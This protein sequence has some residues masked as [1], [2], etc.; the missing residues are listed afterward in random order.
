MSGYKNLISAWYRAVRN[1]AMPMLCTS[2]ILFPSLVQAFTATSLGD[3]G[4]VSVMQVSGNFDAL[5]LDGTVN[6][7]PRQAITK[8]FLKTHKDEYDFVVIFSKFDYKMPETEASAFYSGI[9]NDVRG[10]GQEIF[11]YSAEFGSNGKLQGTIDMGNLSGKSSDPTDPNFDL[12]LSTLAHEMLHRWVARVKFKEADGT[13]STKLL[14]KNG[15]HW[16]YLLD[17]KGSVAYGN[18]WRD[19]GNGT[20]T[21]LA[22]KLYFSPLDLYLMGVRDKS[23]VPPMLLI[24]NPDIDPSTMLHTSATISG[25]A[26][27]ISIDDIVAAEGERLPAAKDSQKQFKMAFIFVTDDGNFSGD[28]LAGIES[29]RNGFLTRFSI[30]TDGKALVQIASTPKEDLPV[31]SGVRPVS[32]TP[33]TLPPNVNEGVSWLMSHQQADGS[34]VDFSLT[35]ARDTAEVAATLQRFPVAQQ[36]LQGG[37]QW[38]ANN[39]SANID[40]L[41]RRIEAVAASGGDAALLLQDLVGRRNLDGGWGSARDFESNATDTALALKALAKAG[42]GDQSVIAKAVAYLQ[43]V[44][45]SDGGWSG[46]DSISTIQPTAAVLAAFNGYRKS[47]SL[48]GNISQAIAFLSGKQNTDGGFGNSPSTV[49]DSALAVMA[50]Q[51]SGA[52]KEMINRGVGYLNGLQ[53]GEGSWQESPYQTALAVRAVWQANVDPDLAVATH[54][55]TFIPAEITVLPTQAVVNV[56][57]RNLGQTDVAQAKVAIYDGAVAP[58]K[59]VGEQTLAFPGS[60][61]VTVTFSVP[62]NDGN[63]HTFYVVVDPDNAVKEASKVN[64]QAANALYPK[65]TYDFET[66]SADFTAAPNTIDMYQEVRLSAKVSN[67]GTMT[68]YNVPVRFYLEDPAAPLEIATVGVDIPAGGTV[69]KE[70]TWKATKAGV[71]TLAVQVDPA[72]T[73]TESSK[74]NNSAAVPITVNSLTREEANLTVSYKDIVLTPNPADQGGK[75]TLDAVVKN[76]GNVDAS[77]VKVSF[78]NGVPGTGG[79]LIGSRTIALLAP[80][81]AQTVSLELEP[82]SEAGTKTVYVEVDP[83]NAVKE[84]SEDDNGAYGTLYIRSFPDIVVSA[85]SMLLSPAAPK[86]GD[87]L[88]F[89][90]GVSNRGEQ[91]ATKVTV[92]LE[93]G[94]AVVGSVVIPVIAGNST[95]TASFNYD[96]AGRQGIHQLT[97]V[98][99][100]DDQL[101][102]Q[103]KDNNTATKTFAVQNSKLWVSEPYFSPNGDGVKDSTHVSFRLDAPG[104]VRVQVLDAQGRTIRSFQDGD[105]T[106]TTGA[107]VT[108]DGRSDEGVVVKDGQ[109]QIQIRDLNDSMVGTVDVVVD[110]NSSPLKEALLANELFKKNMTCKASAVTGNIRTFWL[111][112]ESG[113]VWGNPDQMMFF[114]VNGQEPRLT[115]KDDSWF[116]EVFRRPYNKSYLSYGIDLTPWWDYNRYEVGFYG[117]LHEAKNY[118]YYYIGGSEYMSPV[119]AFIWSPDR[120]KM[121]APFGGK[122]NSYPNNTYSK[123][124]V[125]EPF[126]EDNPYGE[127]SNLHDLYGYGPYSSNITNTV[128]WS[129]DSTRLVYWDLT[130]NEVKITDPT[131]TNKVTLL[132]ANDVGALKWLDNDRILMTRGSGGVE[133]VSAYIIGVNEKS[134]S[135]LTQGGK[136]VLSNDRSKIFLQ[137]SQRDAKVVRLDGSQLGTFTLTNTSTVMPLW[138]PKDRCLA[139]Q[140]TTQQINNY[141]LDTVTVFD[142]ATGE[143]HVLDNVHN[144]TVNWYDDDTLLY[145]KYNSGIVLYDLKTRTAK[146]LDSAGAS[147]AIP[148]PFSNYLVWGGGTSSGCSGVPVYLVS[149]RQ[150]LSAGVTAAKK[151]SSLVISGTAADHNF[152]GWQLEYADRSAPDTWK[153]IAPPSDTPVVEGSFATWVPP[154]EGIYHIRLT[155]WDKAGNNSVTRTTVTWSNRTGIS[156]IYK[157]LDAISPNGDGINDVLEVHYTLPAPVHVDYSVYDSGGALV[158]SGYASAGVDFV[159]WDGRDEAGGIVSDGRYTIALLGA[160]FSFTV[161]NTAPI[162]SVAL[163]ALAKDKDGAWYADLTAVAT[164]LH[165][166]GWKVEYAEG[167]NPSQWLPLMEGREI[168]AKRDDTGSFIDP[169][170]QVTIKSFYGDDVGWLKN[171]KFRISAEDL[172]GNKSY[173]ISKL[174]EEKVFIS[175]WDFKVP[176]EVGSIVPELAKPGNHIISGAETLRSALQSIALQHWNGTVWTDVASAEPSDSGRIEFKWDNSSAS[177]HAFAVRISVKDILGEVHYSNTLFTRS[178]L[179]LKTNCFRELLGEN[180]LFEAVSTLKLQT[181]TGNA[182]WSDYQV[183]DAAKGDVI[184]TECFFV[185]APL[186]P[187]GSQVRMTAVGASGRLYE[188]DPLPYPLNC[189]VKLELGATYEEATQCGELSSG[190]VTLTSRLSDSGSSV[191]LRTLSYYLQKPSGLEPLK[192]YDVATEGLRPQLLQTAGMEEGSYQVKAV[193]SYLDQQDM[194]VKEA[195]AA[196]TVIVDRSLPVAQI[197][198]P[199]SGLQ[200]L[201]PAHYSTPLEWFGLAVEGRASDNIGTK[202]Y[203]LSYG[204]GESPASWSPAA[205]Q[206]AGAISGHGAKQGTLGVW[207]VS[208]LGGGTYSL[209]LEVRDQVG[210]LNCTTTLAVL[211]KMIE[212]P[213]VTAGSQLFSPNSDGINDDLNVSFTLQEAALYDAKVFRLLPSGSLDTTPVRTIYA[214]AKHFAGSEN[215]IWDGKSDAGA[216]VSD[217]RYAVAVTV[218]DG[219]GNSKSRWAATEVDATPPVATISYPTLGSG[220]LLGNLVEVRGSAL[221]AHLQGYI[222][223]AGKGEVPESWIAIASGTKAIDGGIFG[224]WNTYGLEGRWTLRLTVVDQAGNK[225]SG[226][227]VVDLGIRR[228]LIKSMAVSPATFSPNADGKKD[229]G[230]VVY[231]IT[232]N[233]LVDL[234]VSDLKG[235]VVK[236]L[237]HAEASAGS[238]NYAWDGRDN[239]GSLLPDGDYKVKLH[240]VSVLD[241]TVSQNEEVT[242]SLDATPPSIVVAVPAPDAFLN[243]S[244]LDL[245][246]DIYDE[247]LTGYTLKVTGPLGVLLE[248]S[249]T[250]NRTGFSFGIIPELAEESYT[251]VSEAKDA[252]DNAKTTTIPFTVDRTP[253]KATLEAPA[254]GGYFGTVKAQVGF[255]GSVLEK[256]PESYSLKFGVGESPVDWHELASGI[257]APSLSSVAPLK[258]GKGD[259]IADG[260]YTIWLHARDKAALEGDAKIKI[261]VDNTVP[262]VALAALGNEEYLRHPVDLMGTAFDA[263]FER[264]SL[265]LSEGECAGAFKWTTLKTLTSTVK[266]GLLY[267]WKVLPADGEYCLRLSAT[268]RSGGMS[269]AKVAVKVHV[270]A[271]PAPVLSA[272]LDVKTTA[273][274]EWTAN[275]DVVA[276]NVYRNSEKLNASPVTEKTFTDSSLKGGTYGYFVKAVDAAGIDSAPS[277]TVSLTV[278]LAGPVLGMSSPLP[279]ARVSGT[280]DINGTATGDDFKRYTLYQGQGSAPATWNQI[281]GSTAPLPYGTLGKLNTAGFSEGSYTLKLEAE[282]INGNISVLTRA[283]TVDRSAPSQPVLLSAVASGS[284]VSVTWSGN[285]E[286]DLAGYLLMRNGQLVNGAGESFNDMK[287]FLLSG[288]VYNETLSDGSY[289]YLLVAVDTAGNISGFS[290]KKTVKVDASPPHAIL[291]EPA[292]GAKIERATLKASSP[293]LDIVSVQFQYKGTQDGAWSNLGAPVTGDSF[294]STFDPESLG[295]SYGNYSLRSVATDGGGKIDPAPAAITITYADITAPAVPGGLRQST[296]GTSVS[297]SWNASEEAGVNYNVY[298]IS[299]TTRSKINSAWVATSSY[300]DERLA[301]GAY[302]Y[303]VTAIDPFQNE[304]QPSGRV[305]TRIYAPV[306]TETATPV[307]HPLV[308]LVGTNAEPGALVQFVVEGAQRQAP[309]G[310][311]SA[312]QEGRYALEIEL[313]P[314]VNTITAR[315]TD[316]AGNLSR[317]SKAVSV[318]YSVPP[319]APAGIAVSVQGHDVAL[320]W[321]PNPENDVIGYNVFRDGQKINLPTA[322]TSGNAAASSEYW[323]DVARNALDGNA[324]TV[325]TSKISYGTFTPAWWEY[326]MP[327]PQFISSLDIH[328]LSSYYNFSGKDYEVQA[329]VVDKWIPLVKV[330]GNANLNPSYSFNPPVRTDKVRIY[331]SATNCQDSYYNRTSIIDVTVRKE[332]F[333]PQPPYLDQNL[334]DSR[335]RYQVAAVNSVGFEGSRSG[336]AVAEV[337]DI[338]APA[339]PQG[340]AATVAGSAVTLKWLPN[341]ETDLAGYNVYRSNSGAWQKLNT[342]PVQGIQLEDQ[343]LLNGGYAYRLTAVDGVGNESEPTGE[344]AVVVNAA[345]PPAPAN[346]AVV[347]PPEGKKLQLIWEASGGTTAGYNVLRSLT[348]SGGYQKINQSLLTTSSYV[349]T[350]VSNGTRYFY[351]VTA[352]DN[353]GNAGAFSNEVCAVPGD[354]TVP[355]IPI[356]I[357]PVA[358]G[359]SLTVTVGESAVAG[360]A[361]AGVTVKLTNNGE[362]VASTTASL[363]DVVG[364]ANYYYTGYYYSTS[365]DGRYFCS[366]GWNSL[367]LIDLVTGAATFVK[368]NGVAPVTWSPDSKKITFADYTRKITVYDTETGISSRLTEDNSASEG[369]PNWSSDGTKVIF[370][371]T[372]GGGQNAWIKDMGTGSLTQV[373]QGSTIT[374]PKFVPG[375]N[376]VTYFTGWVVKIMDLDTGNTA[377][378]DNN[379]A[380]DTLSWSPDGSR[381]SFVSWNGKYHLY[382]A[383]KGAYAQKR[384]LASVSGWMRATWAQDSRNIALTSKEN[385]SNLMKVVITDI[386]GNAREVVSTETGIDW[387]QWPASGVIYFSTNNG[388]R[389]I[390]PKGNFA[391]SGVKL[392][393]GENELSVTAVDDS[394]NASPA[395]QLASVVYDPVLMPDLALSGEDFTFYPMIAQPGASVAGT[396][397]IRNPSHNPVTNV[398]VD[399]Y[400]WD[401]DGALN[402]VK[403]EIVPLIAAESQETVSFSFNTGSKGGAESVIAIVD[404]SGQIKELDETNNYAAGEIFV[405]DRDGVSVVPTLVTDQYTAMEEVAISV[406][407]HNNGPATTG[408]L[409]VAIEDATGSVVAQLGSSSIDQEFGSQSY[410]LVWNSG[411]TP[412]GTYRVRSTFEAMDGT[413]TEGAIEFEI[414]PDLRLE[415]SVSTDKRSYGPN[416]TVV[417]E[418]VIKN[419][420]STYLIPEVTVKA[421]VSDSQGNQLQMRNLVLKNL[422]PGTSVLLKE[423]WNT[424]L[425]PPGTYRTSAQA[426]V[427]GRELA[428]HSSTF[429]VAPVERVTGTVQVDPSTV[430]I[431]SRII[432][433]YSVGSSGNV[434]ASGI[435]K[436]FVVD[437]QTGATLASAEQEMEFPLN[438]MRI[439]EFTFNASSL[440][441]QGYLLRLQFLSLGTLTAVS[442]TGF[443]VKDLSAPVVAVISP[444]AGEICNSK[445]AIEVLASDDA[446]GV[447]K[448]EYQLDGGPWKPLALVSAAQGRYATAWEPGASE[449]PAHTVSFRATDRSGN[450]STPVTVAFELQMDSTAPV[451]TIDIEGPR[452]EVDGKLYVSSATVFTLAGS[453][454]FSGVANTEYRIDGGAWTPYSPFRLTTAGES[455]V[456]YRSVDNAGNP[457][458]EKSLKVYLDKDAPTTTITA[459]DPLAPGAVNTVSPKTAFTLSATDTGTGIKQVWYRIDEGQWL[460]FTESFTLEEMDAGS[461]TIQFNAIDNVGNEEVKNSVTVRLIRIEVEKEIATEPVVLIGA[462]TDNLNKVKNQG[463]VDAVKPILSSLGVDFLIARDGEEFKTALRSG[464]YNS[465]LLID[466]KDE[467]TGGELREAVNYG[468]SLV[469][470][471]TKPGAVP[472]LEIV[473]GMKLTGETTSEGIPVIVA[474]SPLTT[475]VT[476]QSSGKC[477]VGSVVAD[478]A[479]VFGY[480]DDKRGQV[481]AV[482]YNEYGDGRVVLFTFDLLNSSQKGVAA[483]LLGDAVKLVTPERREARALGTIPIEITV[484]NSTEPVKLR[485]SEMFPAE[486][487]ARDITPEG[488]ASDAAITWLKD[489]DPT[490]TMKFRY[491]LDLPDAKGEYKA[492]TNIYYANHEEYRLYEA[493]ELTLAVGSDSSDLLGAAI[494]DL[495]AVPAVT[496]EDLVHLAELQSRLAQINVKP[497]TVKDAEKEIESLTRVTDLVRGVSADTASVRL[498]LDE[499]LKVLERKWYLLSTPGMDGGPASI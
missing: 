387:I 392:H 439:G 365:P 474:Q 83:E 355:S 272:R 225:S 453:D 149:S 122:F 450:Q 21:S 384:D 263:N 48:E 349:D 110:N 70:V 152:G 427:D 67:K 221:D 292:N 13:L 174:V 227:V 144:G 495:G 247:H 306:L 397:T 419:P 445:V 280:V 368:M 446:S 394:G 358:A 160:D 448:L 352:A 197:T 267:S 472:S 300:L 204:A 258:V 458:Q 19:N 348:A 134:S 142:T 69:T 170:T 117:W 238:Y 224:T 378:I 220:A 496:S 155:A 90:V 289:D 53:T 428:T 165:L 127:S 372:R 72:N 282:D 403:S 447:E 162:S 116:S 391:F 311:V 28:Q 319:T 33:R 479:S 27:Q 128:S 429:I 229:T 139:L 78:Y 366:S 443:T 169:P 248:R 253:P 430:P 386:E 98:V 30:L 18:Q 190:R 359:G 209:R 462:W 222:L 281:S 252:A 257:S 360:S 259:G 241:S 375:A 106:G 131:A 40:Y 421:V 332:E 454:D 381:L 374:Y 181:K 153:P 101:V 345:L 199:A 211:D 63:G 192:S 271:P 404:Q 64:N 473:F 115:N 457:E 215:F 464:K 471:K 265:E 107:V 350:S 385:S 405:A 191:V 361:E 37:L 52:D 6:S 380:P 45:N 61:S 154:G 478:T 233:S 239:G 56:S 353:V 189:P 416:Q 382:V 296:N 121:A 108:W 203:K 88:S 172:A 84:L 158:K 452:Y 423:P 488:A 336:E 424:A 316:G 186:L 62:V 313:S 38:L 340:F 435:L 436:A 50:L 31:N 184:P 418:M 55:I 347:A 49:Y 105:L 497:L 299:E 60:S 273:I 234:T 210:N 205:G 111:D 276:Y 327:A 193:L 218:M 123:L 314:G 175:T 437:P 164:D 59:K 270:L 383:D 481:P 466:Y 194:R 476:L 168:V 444:V 320:A 1:W 17:T 11:D 489:L 35:A 335:F 330:A 182:Q 141:T 451:T 438:E 482:V 132:P 342:S 29:I 124:S 469:Y 456:Y 95:T 395:S 171:K 393:I 286:T 305:T 322:D 369:D 114:P 341:S 412:A 178:L 312:D 125:I 277:N 99:D 433:R 434:A 301:D 236:S 179:T 309:V 219:C 411:G 475:S 295:L 324:S 275:P 343:N 195:S 166:K 245:S 388:V 143:T 442:S 426:F 183:Y 102:E 136:P 303:E 323:S 468:D 119:K 290:N 82:L 43:R 431:G 264:G 216:T 499:L 307:D 338:V 298:R 180:S 148:S 401:T 151:G 86:E 261:V 4:N 284:T 240:V 441:P 244:A 400:A 163:T 130:T 159:A 246:G 232:A 344:L 93:E 85:S 39:A 249:G 364:A 470:I 235:I 20:F 291:V 16:S 356:M 373:T 409:K 71:L 12:T 484:A 58:D 161:D 325:W 135:L 389:K 463:A 420:S 113:Y 26:R 304:S 357:V 112:D 157:N 467:K 326:D 10:I 79:L 461:H 44:Q 9:K 414:L 32:T 226:T 379:T 328:W 57:V 494:F 317:V 42:Y 255:V 8:E 217:G 80:S 75:A 77:K 334:R 370:Y 15:S 294:V 208:S 100:P 254:N 243:L 7:I 146:V 262:E 486:A 5:S 36:Q 87:V 351:V 483:G 120:K 212:T 242:V 293:E 156:D 460:L 214:G 285:A 337:G 283:I 200:S 2:L 362:Y 74:S 138:S 206:G 396:V 118:Y 81:A 440:S 339:V 331:I 399:I 315:A 3:Y 65:V 256:N 425:T 408:T 223:E 188:T 413:V 94:G 377:V 302:T 133:Y 455:T 363:V 279:E 422:L 498:K 51:E 402:N 278:D 46:G 14:G 266:D 485:V 297:L 185:A 274:L 173:S 213:A 346:L 492:V 260:I 196:S 268:D 201:C 137:T 167:H 321:D 202:N 269:E 287:P 406:A 24:E 354:T 490:V 367:K 104:T 103:S 390:S 140:Q 371:S 376:Q 415:S 91:E 54:D 459:S 318:L 231:E 92:Q 187:A 398:P 491:Y 333:V 97:A 410:S 176:D 76:T 477:V 207:D 96:T 89:A 22:G 228:D 237:S 177:G 66:V 432:A 109:F 73:F 487:V 126:R 480:A 493:A 465:Y 34:W 41:A 230:S 310:M 145:R 47:Y 308:T 129:P 150:N 68:A 250:Q 198:A 25:T 147:A 449:L 407:V 251:L 23:Q 417:S 329:W 288:T